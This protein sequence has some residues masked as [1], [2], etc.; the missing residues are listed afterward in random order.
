MKE[1]IERTEID[2]K[3]WILE[4]SRFAG[5]LESG[6]IKYAI[7][8]AGALAVQNVMIRPTIDIDFVV[9]DYDGAVSVM[10]GQPNLKSSNLVKERD[11]IQVADFYFQSGITIQ[12]WNNNMYSLPMTEDS[13]RR[14][15]FK[16][17]AG[18]RSIWS[19]SME[20]LIVSKVGRYTQ[21]RTASEYEANKNARDI[22]ATM[23]SL[24]KPDFKYVIQRLA[25]GARRETLGKFSP[26]HNL[27]GYFAKEVEI[28]RV[29]AESFDSA[30]I[31][32]FVSSVLAQSK[33]L[34]MEYTMLHSIRK[35]KSLKKFKSDFML[36][37]RNYSMLLSR[38]DSFLGI[39]GDKVKVTSKQ[40]Q[41]Y[42]QSLKPEP[43]SDYAKKLI[44]SGKSPSKT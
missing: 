41:D 5:I 21:Q 35:G 6:G 14:I 29:L 32:K 7:L 43:D 15:V 2:T 10:R 8:G 39:D 22:V 26:I 31:G 27:N 19:I 13:W 3:I 11:G 16:S 37:E 44:F 24:T 40:I 38:W 4:A 34:N 1:K 30:K 9:E 36:D 17:V 25:E 42:T 12:I 28:Y 18:Y 23:Q 20:D 33:S